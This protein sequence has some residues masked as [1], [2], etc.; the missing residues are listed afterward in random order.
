MLHNRKLTEQ[1]PA[2]R[3]SGQ[4]Q[5]RERIYTRT[6]PVPSGSAFR[7]RREHREGLLGL[8]R[9]HEGLPFRVRREREHHLQLG[10]LLDEAPRAVVRLDGSAELA[11]EQ[12]FSWLG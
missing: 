2:E 5:V 9:C 10:A 1:P 8:L 7:V 11:V 3:L 6:P 4:V 12:L